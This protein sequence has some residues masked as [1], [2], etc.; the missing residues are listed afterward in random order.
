M[1]ILGF[2]TA[3][4]ISSNTRAWNKRSQGWLERYVYMRTG[5]LPK[6]GRLNKE[7]QKAG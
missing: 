7:G 2:E 1:D 6:K 5:A 3:G 4:H